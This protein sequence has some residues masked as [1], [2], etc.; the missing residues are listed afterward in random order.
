MPNN[1]TTNFIL[2]RDFRGGAHGR[3][4]LATSLTGCV[5]VLK[6]SKSTMTTSLKE[7]LDIWNNIWKIPAFLTSLS[8]HEVLV[9]PFVSG[10]TFEDA[11]GNDVIK[12]AVIA[13][14]RK[15]AS[16][17][18]LHNDLQRVFIVFNFN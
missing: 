13:A 2:L 1:K 7:E 15:L 18:K 10:C 4:W 17:N 12:A 3:A 6:F 11:K 5:C 14:I 16:K 9:M 8:G